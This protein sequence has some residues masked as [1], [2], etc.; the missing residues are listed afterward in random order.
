MRDTGIH[1]P[2]TLVFSPRVGGGSFLDKSSKAGSRN[3]FKYCE[4]RF[5]IRNSTKST[6]I[7]KIMSPVANINS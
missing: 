4:A 2:I 1:T 3:T 7:P 6:K 5:I